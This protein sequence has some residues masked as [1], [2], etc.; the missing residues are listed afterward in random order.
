MSL[1]R[2]R[3]TKD[4]TITNAY[5][6]NLTTRG[7]SGNMGQSDILEVFHIYDQ[8]NA[9][10]QE[11][12]RIL[13]E[14]D[15]SQISTDRSAGVIPASGSVNFFLKLYDAEHTQTT[16]KDYTLVVSAVSQSW[17]EGIGLDMENY[18][19]IDSS[20]WLSA[21]QGAPWADITGQASA[22]ITVTD[23]GG[24]LNDQTFI[25]SNS[26]GTGTTYETNDTIAFGSQPGGA[27]GDT[28]QLGINGIGGGSSGKINLAAAIAAS[29]NAT[30]NTDF[31]AASDGVDKVTVTQT[32]PG[33]VGNKSNTNIDVD[34][35]TVGSFTGGEN[36][37]GGSYKTGS[38]AS[39]L[40]YLFTQSFD[41]GYENLEI[42]VSHLVEDWIH[43]ASGGGLDNYG[44]GIQLTSSLEEATVSYYTKM[45][46]ARGSQF[47]FKRPVLEARWDSSKKDHRG[48]FYLSSSLIPASDNLMNLY[49][50]NVVRGSLTDIPAVGTDDILVSIYS[51]STAPVGD[52]LFLPVGNDVIA[53][54]DVNIT[55]SWAETGIYSASFAYASSSITKIYDVWHSGSGGGASSTQYHTGSAI[56]V[57]TFDSQDYSIDQKYVTKVTNL[58]SS[59]STQETARFRL[60]TRQKD[61]SPTN[62]TVSTSNI[63]TSI[64]EDVYYKIARVPDNFEVIPYGTGSLDHTRL[65]YDV[66]GSYFDLKMDLF[67]K[68]TVYE[69]SF[70]YVIK[71]SNVEQP[72]KFRFRVE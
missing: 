71:D 31:T 17:E 36:V 49:L 20:N 10:S 13:L 41:N 57:K 59:Y 9:A 15:I 40:E 24:T 26:V 53:T 68:D 7:V 61:W 32:T 56:T 55:A 58:R 43:G 11:N 64:V 38:A 34:G 35:I 45:F 8:A 70:I 66:S 1:K 28:I 25:L 48:N 22:E 39:P 51:G 44:F 6:A 67:D 62:Y 52:K 19:D 5:K 23:A 30:T 14:Y 47:F 42:D 21:S 12:A 29:I 72:E 3:P 60:Y 69:L 27:V 50:Y 33:T 63:K 18:T 46:F 65:S 37:E 16:P 54:G 2:Y 4:N